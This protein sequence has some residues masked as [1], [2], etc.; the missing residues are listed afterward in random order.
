V[1]LVQSPLVHSVIGAAIEVHR[2]LGP[3][4]LESVYARGLANE[5]DSRDIRFRAQVSVPVVYKGRDLGIGLRA[6]FIVENLL[7]LELKSTDR[8]APIHV[9]QVVTYLRL[10][11]LRQGLLINFNGRKLVHGLKNVLV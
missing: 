8:L 5:L 1:L 10:L 7:L 3:G 6:D 2:H 9:A 4:L 11:D